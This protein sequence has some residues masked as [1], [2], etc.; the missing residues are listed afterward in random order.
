[1]S[2]VHMAKPE[3]S[4]ASEAFF[5]GIS[6]VSDTSTCPLA[7]SGFPKSKDSRTCGS[8]R[9]TRS[10]VLDLRRR[11]RRVPSSGIPRLMMPRFFANSMMRCSVYFTGAMPVSTREGTIWEAMSPPGFLRKRFCASLMMG[12][13]PS[14]VAML[15]RSSETMRSA[16]CGMSTCIESPW[17]T[18]MTSWSF[19]FCT[20]FL[21]SSAAVGLISMAYTFLAPAFAAMIASSARAPVPMSTTVAST[22]VAWMPLTLFSMTAW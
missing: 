9:K 12:S 7:E 19:C 3:K 16:F 4:L 17:M 8:E 2:L 13:T 11:G 6:N 15:P 22:P 1:M 21:A 10:L 20:S 14:C 18:S 5:A